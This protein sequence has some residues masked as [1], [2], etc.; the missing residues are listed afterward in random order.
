[1][2]TT[3]AEELA[4]FAEGLTNPS[5]NTASF[6][7]NLTVANV[8]T[9]G[10]ATINSTN[11]TGTANN[12]AFVG[13]TSAANVVS[14][15]Q[16]SSN[17]SAYQTTAGLA[18]NVQT[19][20]AN[21]ANYVGTLIAANVVSN[22]QLSSNLGNYQT[23]AG[24]ATN[25]ATLTANNANNLG[26]TLAASFVQN[27]DTRTLSGNLTLSGANVT[28]T[29]ANH[30]FTGTN[31][32]FSN[33]NIVSNLGVAAKLT[34]NATVANV[35]NLGILANGSVGSAPRVLTSNGSSTYW[36]A[37]AG[38]KAIDVMSP[39]ATDN[40]AFFWTNDAITILEL[41]SVI[42]GTGTP[43]LTHTWYFGSDRTGGTNTVIQSGI[44]TTSTTTGNT[45]TSFACSAVAAGSFIWFNITAV[46]TT[47]QFHVTMRY[48]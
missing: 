43:S 9:V 11:F 22:A 24:L 2:V 42:T 6:S 36:G 28:F 37:P 27:T 16:L 8:L 31:A 46:T 47:T 21:A 19:L 3:K 41:R 12:T 10:T 29:G 35:G 15:T 5:A 14:N 48:T 23:T 34:V 7:G 4:E 13:S 30:T 45:Q 18:T 26:G 33:V 20:T 40:W 1:M 32:S 17:L 38:I 44:V 39:T 25:V